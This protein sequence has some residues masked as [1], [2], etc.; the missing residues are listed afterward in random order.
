[1][2]EGFSAPEE[3]QLDRAPRLV[4]PDLGTELRKWW[5]GR[6]D[7]P[8]RTPNFDLAST[9]SFEGIRGL[10]LVEAKAHDWELFHA[11]AGRARRQSAS[12]VGT[13]EAIGAAIRQA[14][15][16]LEQATGLEWGIDRDSHYQLSNRVAWGWRLATLGIPVVLVYLGFL[17]ADEMADRGKP[18]ASHDEWTTLV[19]QHGAEYVPESVW[20]SRLVVGDVPLALL[21]RSVHVTLSGNDRDCH[22][23]ET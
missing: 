14:R 1:M 11:A 18:F 4:P 23:S 20:N 13:R 2:P 3:A 16:G 9:C 17:D 8:G 6:T 12:D 10:L 7:T 21:I 19:E 15:Y 5:L 22:E